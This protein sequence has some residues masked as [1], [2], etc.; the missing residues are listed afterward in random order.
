MLEWFIRTVTLIIL[1][2]PWDNGRDIIRG[3]Y[4]AALFLPPGIVCVFQ[5]QRPH[6]Y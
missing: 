1:E 2:V 6:D 3:S 5:L 4:D